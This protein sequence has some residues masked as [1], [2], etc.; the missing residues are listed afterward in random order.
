[1]PRAKALGNNSHTTHL[2]LSDQGHII[3]DFSTIFKVMKGLEILHKL[4]RNASFVSVE[5]FVHVE[6]LLE[7][8]AVNAL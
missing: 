3:V 7:F 4:V 6:K 5:E 8:I 1:M 2:D